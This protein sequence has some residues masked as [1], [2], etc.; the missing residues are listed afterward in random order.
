MNRIF[1]L[2]YDDPNKK[3]PAEINLQKIA[4]RLGLGYSTI[5]HKLKEF[6]D[7]K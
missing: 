1:K 5:L 4:Q 2:Y 6:K 3:P 7:N